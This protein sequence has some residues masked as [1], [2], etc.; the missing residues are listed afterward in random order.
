MQLEPEKYRKTL[1]TSISIPCNVA[2]DSE[3][4]ENTHPYLAAAGVAADLLNEVLGFADVT[5]GNDGVPFGPGFSS[6]W[7]DPWSWAEGFDTT[8]VQPDVQ[9]TTG[10]VMV[11]PLKELIPSG[12]NFRKEALI[13]DIRAEDGSTLPVTAVENSLRHDWELFVTNPQTGNLQSLGYVLFSDRVEGQPFASTGRLYFAPSFADVDA[14]IAVL[15][16]N[17]TNHLH[18]DIKP[19]AEAVTGPGADPSITKLSLEES[20][21]IS[22]G[23]E[24]LAVAADQATTTG[25]TGA[26]LGLV[27][28]TMPLTDDADPALKVSIGDALGLES[29]LEDQLVA[30]AQQYLATTSEPTVADFAVFLEG[31]QAGS[32]DLSAGDFFF[33]VVSAAPHAEATG[34]DLSVV[35]KRRVMRELEFGEDGKRKGIALEGQ[36][37]VDADGDED[38]QFPEVPLDVEGTFDLTFAVDDLG[39]P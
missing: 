24:S 13:F 30:P 9:G 17:H 26:P 8:T 31:L 37:I 16:A 12:S 38:V 7:S 2:T 32:A 23:L 19:P 25:A 18:I 6:R 5:V 20:W 39:Q 29:L 14:S 1:N 27:G 35:A 33:D 22:S 21:A 4:L 36:T 28:M 3:L 10:D 11:V 15:D 34:F